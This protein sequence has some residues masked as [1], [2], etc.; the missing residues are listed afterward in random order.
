MKLPIDKNQQKKGGGGSFFT[1]THISESQVR[2][3]PVCVCR[4]SDKNN[5]VKVGLTLHR[6]ALLLSFSKYLYG[7]HTHTYANLL[8]INAPKKRKTI[9][10][11]YSSFENNNKKKNIYLNYSND[12]IGSRMYLACM[13]ASKAL[14]PLI[15]REM[16]RPRYVRAAIFATCARERRLRPLLPILL[17]SA[18]KCTIVCM[19]YKYL[20]LFFYLFFCPHFLRRVFSFSPIVGEHRRPRAHIKGEYIY[21]ER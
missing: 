21:R 17:Y 20:L 11:L 9:I 3:S 2:L 13:C 10:L 1:H 19:Y 12:L 14:W 18:D 8:H 16:R 15:V 4:F 6:V 7:I 5:I